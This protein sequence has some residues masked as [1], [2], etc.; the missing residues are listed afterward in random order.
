MEKGLT[1]LLLSKQASPHPP[2]MSRDICELAS[3][4]DS[5]QLV[6]TAQRLHGIVGATPRMCY[7][8]FLPSP[9][10]P[11]DV[12]T[13]EMALNAYGIAE[14]TLQL[15]RQLIQVPLDSSYD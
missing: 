12:Y 6:T 5:P 2:V 15:I 10:T 13:L 1:A 7:P 4:T 9:K 11:R 14:E 8:D 3:F